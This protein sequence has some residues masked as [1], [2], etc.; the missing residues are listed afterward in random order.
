MRQ[1]TLLATVAIRYHAIYLDVKKEDINMQSPIPPH[2]LAFVSQLKD[3]GFTVTEQLLHAL[4]LVQEEKL[5]EI[6]DT[7][8]HLMGVHLNWMPLVKGWKVPT[9]ETLADHFIT[10]IANIFGEEAGFKGERLQ[11]GHLIPEGTFNLER[12]NG[13]PFCGMPFRTADYVFKGQASKLKELRLFTDE[14]MKNALVSL[15]NSPT[16]LNGTQNSSLEM[17]LGLYGV[18]E[19]V[20]ISIKETEI[21]VVQFLI[22][23]KKG[24][25]AA[26]ILRTPM[27]ILRFMWF[28]KTGR[29]RLVEPRTIAQITKRNFSHV[30][31]AEEKALEAVQQ[32]KLSLKL[33]YNRTWCR[34]VAVWLNATPMT[35]Q[36]AAENMNPKREMW[37]RF[38][39]ALRLGEY[40]RKRGYAHLAE[41]LDVFYKKNYTTWKGLIDTAMIEKDYDKCLSLL[42]ERPGAFARCLF[43]T[44]LNIGREKTLDAFNEVADKLPARLLLSLANAAPMYFDVC[45]TRLA[46]PI[47]GLVH[48]LDAHPKL[49]VYSEEEINGM[50]YAINDIY[51]NSMC[52]RFAAQPTESKTIYIDEAMYAIPIEVGDRSET[53]QTFSN[54]PQG[55]RFVVEGD[56]VRLFLQWGEGLPAQPLDMDLSCRI[57]HEGDIVEDCAYYNLTCKGAKHS[58]DIRNIPEKVGTAEYIELNIPELMDSL[59]KY[60]VFT[61]N[62]YSVGSL[63]P[64]LKVGW[65]NSEF[66]MKVSDKDGVAY[67]PSCVQQMVVVGDGNL[68]KGLI[69]GV[70]IVEERTIVWMELP[71]IGQYAAKL[72]L[73]DM[74]SLLKILDSK[75]SIGQLL[76]LKAEAQQLKIVGNK[77]D[78]DEAYTMEWA[79]DTAKVNELLNI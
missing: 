77:D 78:A 65:M 6:S 2:V 47:T 52:K 42:K 67:D 34:R 13:C 31:P 64:N 74:M 45:A 60:V 27:D 76:E 8:G 18:P 35:A 32:V 14:D 12:Y 9:G 70:L 15:L 62:A 5:L 7:I 17:L 75:I 44:M 33:K 37:V 66:P 55:T 4:A 58:G 23:S 39:R 56:S 29:Q 46:R 30:N 21:K 28:V 24:D 59:A 61:C 11:C 53:I 49:S 40:S 54:T 3:N 72:N 43:P 36:Q 16:P 57:I 26:K 51:K 1:D 50:I 10:F 20:N 71:Y 48:S 79:Y 41:I 25:E 69:F 38:I 73:K 63:S 68:S 22:D 19:N